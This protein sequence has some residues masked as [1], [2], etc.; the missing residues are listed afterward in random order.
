M[1][2]LA[3]W[4]GALGSTLTSTEEESTAISTRQSRST[5]E[6]SL[7][8]RSSSSTSTGSSLPEATSSTPIIIASSVLPAAH[9]ILSGAAIGGIAVGG[10]I[11]LIAIVAGIVF[12][13]C[14]RRRRQ[15]R[16]QQ[17]QQQQ[18]QYAAV[19]QAPMPRPPATFDPTQDYLQ[20]GIGGQQQQQQHENKYSAFKPSYLNPPS[21]LPHQAGWP[22]SSI[23][24]Y[25]P[26][27]EFSQA[28]STVS[29]VVSPQPLHF[30]EM[31]KKGPSPEERV[32]YF[33][34]P[35]STGFS[36]LSEGDG[37]LAQDHHPNAGLPTQLRV[38]S[39]RSQVYSS[40]HEVPTATTTTPEP[41]RWELPSR[42]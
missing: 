15:R 12:A 25:D 4:Y 19:A 18:Y 3:D 23:Q 35:T 39:P 37:L 6:S 9:R 31:P 36:E 29:T 40:V 24:P 2:S 10:A 5:T 1:E 11:V 34:P 8:R 28:A 21:P 14:Y 27:R 7:P 17:Q 20:Q 16:E 32:G 33:S 30:D 22:P 13:C 26:S 41:E 42:P 38:G